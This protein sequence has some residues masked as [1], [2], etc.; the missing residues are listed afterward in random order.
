M[1][2]FLNAALS[3]I[4][5]LLVFNAGLCLSLPLCKFVNAKYIQTPEMES[6]ELFFN[7]IPE[8]EVFYLEH[9]DRFVIDI[10]NSYF[11]KVKD[12]INPDS[13]NI[14][15]IRIS[16]FRPDRVRL[17]IDQK[18]AAQVFIQKKNL[19][20]G[21]LLILS[22]KLTE[23]HEIQKEIDP[24]ASME[25]LTKEEK[26]NTIFGS[27]NS[28]QSLSPDSA[29]SDDTPDKI[30]S[31]ADTLSVSGN[32]KNETAYRLV[33]P[34]QLSKIKNTF[35]LKASG[36]L[37]EDVSFVL[38]SRVSYD[39]VYDLSDNYNDKVEKDQRVI[40]DLRDA[41]LDL[42]LG[43]FDFRLGNQQIVWGQ[44]VGL[45]FADL[46]NPLNL[47]E[48]ILPKLE[49]LR[50]PVLAANMEY[51]HSDFYFQMIFI[52]FPEFNE[53]GEA[54]SE[55]DF[56][57]QLYAQDADIV[58]NDPTKPANS[59]D[60]SE[61]GFRVSKLMDG[62]D[63]SL[64]YL[65][66]MY[67]SPVNYRVISLNPPGSQHPATITYL[68]KY[69]RIHRIGT[70]FSKDY[71]D[72][73]FKGEFIYNNEMYFQSSDISDL[74]GVETSDTF[75]W[76]L[77]ADYTFFDKLE[78]N[79]QLMQNIILDHNSSMI[80]KEYK[81]SFS[82]WLKTGFFENKIEPELFFI[83]SLDQKDFMLRPSITYNYSGSLKFIL[84]ADAFWGEPDG[85]FGI[86]RQSDR[87]YMEALYNF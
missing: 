31:K 81:T 69:E 76:L 12:S 43:N 65:Y 63:M 53:F 52:P 77:G 73:I 83:S 60:N 5:F 71:H 30:G 79:F 78:T 70:T 42:S 74:D 9:P 66:D 20:D 41:Y 38:G 33:Q 47:R 80:Q 11:P 59:M 72:V 32:L 10:K 45:F 57:K 3:L 24:V 56:S 18:I 36:T 75:D 46:V 1:L 17:V 34:H 68:P 19:P 6:I 50:I 84:G 64:F 25:P 67:N 2:R 48:F 7:T 40:A 58:L 61:A 54:G 21:S 55:F 26:P 35:N 13:T 28:K 82:A 37:S 23:Q 49:E 16:Q 51:F 22:M 27:S 8:Y 39:P 4:L 14:H 85:D 15:K 86:F 87:I 44:A 62:W 29:V